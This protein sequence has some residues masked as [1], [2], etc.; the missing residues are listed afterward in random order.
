MGVNRE[1]RH[2]SKKFKVE[3][4]EII[5]TPIYDFIYSDTFDK[6]EVIHNKQKVPLTG[7]TDSSL[8]NDISIIFIGKY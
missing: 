2:S 1:E 4:K 5:Y 8:N 7:K 6:E 3:S